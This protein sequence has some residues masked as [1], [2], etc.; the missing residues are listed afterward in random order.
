MREVRDRS[1]SYTPDPENLTPID[2]Y[3]IGYFR[4]DGCISTRHYTVFAQTELEPVVE[5]SKYLRLPLSRVRSREYQTNVPRGGLV[6]YQ[7]HYICSTALGRVYSQ[8][9]VK[10]TLADSRPYLSPHFWRGLIDGDGSIH[11]KPEINLVRLNLLANDEDIEA[12]ADY[13]KSL[14]NKRPH[15]ESLKNIF[16]IQLSN[17]RAIFILKSL[18]LNQ[19]SANAKKTRLA[20]QAIALG[21][22]HRVRTYDLS[23]TKGNRK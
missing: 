19:Y 12:F 9:G 2:E 3:W 14:I 13:C 11:I 22:S 10:G 4:A 6:T 23:A 15:V 1:I 20:E 16:R 7:G 18:Y 17:N 21:Y 5:L 8:L